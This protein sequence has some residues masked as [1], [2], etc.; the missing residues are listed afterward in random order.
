MVFSTVAGATH[1]LILDSNG[2]TIFRE[3]LVDNSCLEWSEHFKL[4]AQDGESGDNFGWSVS[5]DGD[6]AIVGAEGD[7]DNYENCG[8]CR[9]IEI[10]I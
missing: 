9:N 3:E 8:C 10:T 1:A 6:Y 7:D 4:L 5:I 2:K